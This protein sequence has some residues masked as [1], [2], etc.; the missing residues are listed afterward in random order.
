MDRELSIVGSC[1]KQRVFYKSGESLV[2]LH[3]RRQQGMIFLSAARTGERHFSFDSERMHWGAQV[4]REVTCEPPEPLYSVFESIQHCVE[5]NRE[6]TQLV[7]R[8]L[9]LQLDY[10]NVMRLS[11]AGNHHP[12]RVEAGLVIRI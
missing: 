5:S 10:V 12:C 3:V 6:L 4:V 8:L 9:E 11:C 7:R 1:E 2:F